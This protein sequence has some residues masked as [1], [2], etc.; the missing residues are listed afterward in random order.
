MSG[1]N[2]VFIFFR[3]LSSSFHLSNPFHFRSSFAYQVPLHQFI[4]YHQLQ[5][6]LD[7]VDNDDDHL[8]YDV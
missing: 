1:T 2:R 4:A 7:D 5:L 8:S 6:R 3:L